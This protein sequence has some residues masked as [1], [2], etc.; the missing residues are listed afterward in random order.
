[1]FLLMVIDNLHVRWAVRFVGPF[2]TDPPLVVDPNAVLA[3]SVSPQRLQPVAGQRAKV[4]EN[5]GRLQSVPLQTG[6]AF[7]SGERLYPFTGGKILGPL[8]SVADDQA[9]A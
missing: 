1:M 6:G 3:L 7:D 4:L 2:K 9:S 8:I 5:G